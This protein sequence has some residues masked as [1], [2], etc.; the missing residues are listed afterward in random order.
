M[1]VTEL[2]SII[3]LLETVVVHHLGQLEEAGLVSADGDAGYSY[4][5]LAPA[6]SEQEHRAIWSALWDHFVPGADD[7]SVREDEARLQETLRLRLGEAGT[8]SAARG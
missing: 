1:S 8:H 5:R 4:C 3:G 6:L 2:T 7:A